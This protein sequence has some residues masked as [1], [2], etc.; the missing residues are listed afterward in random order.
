MSCVA[1]N[2]RGWEIEGGGSRESGSRS[3]D[4]GL[5][6]LLCMINMFNLKQGVEVKLSWKNSKDGTYSTSNAYEV[7]H[8]AANEPREENLKVAFKWVWNKMVSQK[9]KATT[10]R[11][12]WD[13]LP[14]KKNLVKRHILNNLN[15]TTC[16]ICREKVESRIFISIMQMYVFGVV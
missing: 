11:I 10:W 3:E 2:R 14:T 9:V 8:V 5:N 12:L 7:I 6:E 13:R 15:E 16:V 4:A 1:I